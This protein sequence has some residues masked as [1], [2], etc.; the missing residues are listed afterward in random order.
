MTKSTKTS[1]PADRSAAIAKSWKNKTTAAARNTKDRVKTGGVEYRS[2][3]AAFA[4]LG[5]AESAVIPFRKELKEKGRAVLTLEDGA[6]HTF[7]IVA[8]AE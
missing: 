7:T 1:A 6:K 2:V 8:K 5:V 3:Q 4:A